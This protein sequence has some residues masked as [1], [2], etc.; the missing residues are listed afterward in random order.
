MFQRKTPAMKGFMGLMAHSGTLRGQLPQIIV[1]HVFAHPVDTHAWERPNHRKSTYGSHLGTM[2]FGQWS[3]RKSLR[4]LAFSLKRQVRPCYHQGLAA[5]LRS[6]LANANHQRPAVIFT[7]T[8]YQ[9]YKKPAAE[10]ASQPQ[11]APKIKIVDSTTI[12][13][14]QKN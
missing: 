7:K 1:R 3:V 4:D 6:T 14:P 12:D 9:L 5:V 11:K 13:L 2:L 10:L 8:Y